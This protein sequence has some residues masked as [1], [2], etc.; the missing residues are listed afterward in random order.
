MGSDTRPI[1][2]GHECL[3]E[4]GQRCVRQACI[5]IYSFDSIYSLCSLLGIA[6]SNARF[7]PVLV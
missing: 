4:S 7:A 5:T 2:A 1:V 3:Q 6:R